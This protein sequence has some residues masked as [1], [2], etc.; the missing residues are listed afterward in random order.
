MT[1]LRLIHGS[2]GVPNTVVVRQTQ[3]DDLLDELTAIH[4]ES[5]ECAAEALPLARQLLVMARAYGPR[6]VRTAQALIHILERQ[7]RRY[8][9]EKA[10]A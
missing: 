10:A 2:R 1:S 5:Y 8:D 3:L 9:P 7:T 4:A 6:S